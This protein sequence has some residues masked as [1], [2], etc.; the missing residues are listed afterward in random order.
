MPGAFT[1]T[2]GGDTGV[3][4]LVNFTI[5]GTATV[6]ADYVSIPASVTIPAGANSATVTVAPVADDIPV[7]ATTVVLTLAPQ[8][9]YA[10]GTAASDTVTIQDTP[11]NAWR[12]TNFTAADLANPSLTGDLADYDGDGIVNLLE[13][14]FG[15]APKT[16][17]VSGLPVVGIQPGGALSLAYTHVKSAADIT[18]IAEVSND[19]A[20]W[21]SG[22]AYTSVI[23]TAD[24]GATE[25][26]T[27]GSLLA[28]DAGQRQFM[29]VRIT[30]P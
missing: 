20:T 2:R 13:Y 4:L 23:G 21:N 10:I 8:F 18:Y 19:L 15:L 28:P 1:L 27:V 22:A 25:T 29:R 16:P 3:P 5:G 26:V 9:S 17:G 12:F 11:F 7:G 14:A 6:G 30:R 24:H